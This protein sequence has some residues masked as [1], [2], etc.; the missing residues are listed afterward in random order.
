[1]SYWEEVAASAGLR[2][3]GDTTP[4]S[5]TLSDEPDLVNGV[6][7]D[8]CTGNDW[9]V[10]YAYGI[11][12]GSAKDVDMI[13]VYMNP[14]CIPH[15]TDYW[16]NTY[17]GTLSVYYSS[18]NSTWTLITSK[19]CSEGNLPLR[20]LVVG[21]VA[22]FNIILGS[23]INARYF[24]VVNTGSYKLYFNH[25]GSGFYSGNA[26]GA[27]KAFTSAAGSD[28]N[29]Y[30]GGN[31]LITLDPLGKDEN[32]ALSVD[33]LTATA[34]DRSQK[35]VRAT[36]AIPSGKWY[37]EVT[38]DYTSGGSYE[39]DM[40]VG[41]GTI[42]APLTSTFWRSSYGWAVDAQ[43][44]AYETN[45]TI[46][47]LI[48]NWEYSRDSQVKIGIAFDRASGKIWFIVADEWGN[49]NQVGD[50]AAGTG[51]HISGI[52][53]SEIYPMLALYEN[54]GYHITE[55]TV[56]FGASAFTH[57]IPSGFYAL[58]EGIV[59]SVYDVCTWDNEDMGDN[60]SLDPTLL[61]ATHA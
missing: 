35:S 12:L 8:Q 44:R 30:T 51:A 59:E 34:L 33:Y 14:G 25:A 2:L 52:T 29:L 20:H 5:S 46:G 6:L 17:N 40:C 58:C 16:R 21:G 7:Y 50:P 23:T 4:T 27:I 48:P 24:K 19:Y 56:N 61:I 41:V 54:D 10:D 42:D 55:M 28:P 60:V 49:Y 39:A 31:S 26:P 3:E 37:W 15:P 43:G 9:E 53:G 11:D 36:H 1:M 22:S 32:I 57:Y 47:T 13:R 38:I 45:S 18:D